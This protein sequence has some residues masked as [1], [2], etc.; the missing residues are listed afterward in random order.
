MFKTSS[1]LV[2]IFKCSIVF[3]YLNSAPMFTF[4]HFLRS[5][6]VKSPL[7]FNFQRSNPNCH[8]LHIFFVKSTISYIFFSSPSRWNP[9]LST[10]A[11]I[12]KIPQEDMKPGK[13]SSWKWSSAVKP[14]KPPVRNVERGDFTAWF[15]QMFLHHVNGMGV[16]PP[17]LSFNICKS[18][19][20]SRVV[21]K[22]MCNVLTCTA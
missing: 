17:K 13:D 7:S 8:G 4:H 1:S 12:K 10:L 6:P 11:T 16:D 3:I 21:D 5:N 15:N 22:W 14:V 20:K 2:L 19:H 18:H 9:T